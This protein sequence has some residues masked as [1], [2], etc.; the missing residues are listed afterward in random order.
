MK[1]TI[2]KYSKGI[3]ILSAVFIFCGCSKPKD[4]KYGQITDVAVKNVGLTGADVEIVIPVDNPNGYDIKVDEAALDLSQDNKVIAHIT[5]LYPVIITGKSKADYKV[6]ASI[7]LANAGALMS[8]M[9]L[10]KGSKADLNLDGT[11]KAHSG[12]FTKTVQVHQTN[13]Q[14]YLRPITDKMKFF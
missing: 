11:L 6:G 13:I 5:Q 4:L 14:D 3:I 10:M 9:S 2:N 7:K 12:L 8:L 1:T